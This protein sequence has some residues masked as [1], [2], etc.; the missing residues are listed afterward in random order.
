LEKGRLREGEASLAYTGVLT[1]PALA[2]QPAVVHGV[3][4]RALGSM[5][6]LDQDSSPVTPAR[7]AF[8]RALDLDPERITVAGAVHG[9]E[10]ARVDAWL[11][12]V[13]GVDALITDRPRQ[14]LLVTCA[15]CYAVVVLDPARPAL[16]LVHAGWR[17]TA[18]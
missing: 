13:P 18:A 6:R 14:P 4:T 3:C 11:P 5:R 7:R 1:I 9:A 16:A 15:D 10:V 2:A 12:T 17:G 8:A